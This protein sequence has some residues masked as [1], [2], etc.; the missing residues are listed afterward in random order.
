MRLT[1]LGHSTVLL[2]VGDVRVLADPL[3][4]RHA[5][6]LRRAWP[7]PDP[8]LGQ[9]LDAVLLSHLHLD[10]ADVRSLRALPEGTPVI[11]T[12]AN[13]EWVRRKGLTGVGLAVGERRE[14]PGDVVVTTVPAVHGTHRPMRHRPNDAVGHL[15][16]TPGTTV[17][18]VGDTGPG[19]FLDEVPAASLRGRVDVAVVPVWG[20]GSRLGEEHLDPDE[21][22]RTCARVGAEV[23][24]PVHWGTFHVPGL[25]RLPRGW[26]GSPGPRFV[27]VLEEHAP[28]CRGVLL[29]PGGS[30]E[31]PG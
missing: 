6:P 9:A 13:V 26:F 16:E 24:V 25:S 20:W 19:D 12:P 8:S 28:G 1:W 31:L 2:E 22:A 17:W 23:A 29:P 4:R 27:E 7:R 11:S 18:L 21:A 14:L 15:V 3:L 5:A 30:V 10:H